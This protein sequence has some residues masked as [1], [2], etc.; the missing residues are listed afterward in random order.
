MNAGSAV[1]EAAALVATLHDYADVAD[2][3]AANAIL[4]RTGPLDNE[5]EVTFVTLAQ[6]VSLSLGLL[7]KFT[8]QPAME[9][10]ASLASTGASPNVRIAQ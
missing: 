2:V 7:E 1:A 9:I 8:G 10:L 4:D 3:M 5:Q 6:W